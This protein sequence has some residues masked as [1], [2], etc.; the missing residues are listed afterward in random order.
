MRP[1]A[2]V[3][4]AIVRI[5]ETSLAGANEV[6]GDSQS[7]TTRYYW[8]VQ[9]PNKMSFRL[10]SGRFLFSRLYLTRAEPNHKF[11]WEIILCG[12]IQIRVFFVLRPDCC[13]QCSTEL[14]HST[15]DSH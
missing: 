11:R 4:I 2:Y 3:V 14:L 6:Y 15:S 1:C 7:R 10:S 9:L 13:R 5:Q 8:P 12:R